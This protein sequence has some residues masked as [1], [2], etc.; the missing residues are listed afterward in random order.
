M[1][2]HV[3]TIHHRHGEDVTVA[4]TADLAYAALDDYVQEWWDQEGEP[5]IPPLPATPEARRD[6]YFKERATEEWYEVNE[7]TVVE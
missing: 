5:P 1:L 4:T 2:V 7:Q 3:L 6:Q